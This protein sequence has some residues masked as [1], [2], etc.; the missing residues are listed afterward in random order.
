MVI[1]HN[2]LNIFVIQTNTYR[3][4][5]KIPAKMYR[6]CRK[7]TI[8]NLYIFVWINSLNGVTAQTML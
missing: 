2:D 1:F 8:N 7:M 3:L 4:Y 5:K 6:L